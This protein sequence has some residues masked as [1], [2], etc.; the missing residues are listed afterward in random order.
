MVKT[1]I[2]IKYIHINKIGKL[3]EYVLFLILKNL[4][5]CLFYI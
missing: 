3:C 5:F 1:K 4:F 2:S